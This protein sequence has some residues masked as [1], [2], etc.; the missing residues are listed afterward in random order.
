MARKLPLVV[1]CFLAIYLI[2]G[3]TYLAVVLGLESIPPLMLMGIRSIAGGIILLTLGWRGIAAVS[4]GTWG[5]AMACGLLFFLGCHGILAYAQQTVPTGIAAI[6]LATVPFWILLLEYVVPGERRPSPWKLL[7]LL[8]G[9]AGV[10][11]IAWQNISER[12]V[13]AGPILL[14]LASALSWAAGSLLSKRT[15]SAGSGVSISGMQLATGGVALLLVSLVIGEFRDFSS[16]AVSNV[17]LAALA[18]LILAGSV[19]GFAAF[20]WLL[21]NVPTTQVSTYTF[22]NPVVAVGL[23]WFF[24]QER[25]SLSMLLGGVMVVASVVAIWRTESISDTSPAK[26][27]RLRGLSLAPTARS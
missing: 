20:H 11:L 4:A 23:G 25:L 14:L 12:P 26:K 24:L 13:G 18:Y 15:S 16:G 27:A 9:F 7:A 8:P 3:S 17:S 6:V 21:D 22:V 1:A 10:A 2:W 19:V 5:S